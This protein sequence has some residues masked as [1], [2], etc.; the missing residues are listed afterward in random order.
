MNDLM[1]INLCT[2]HPTTGTSNIVPASTSGVKADNTIKGKKIKLEKRVLRN[3]TGNTAL[4]FN[5]FF[6]NT[7]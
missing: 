7:S 5:D 6:L 2:S 1:M 4:S 3:K